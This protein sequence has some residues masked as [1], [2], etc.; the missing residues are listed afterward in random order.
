[1]YYRK[2]VGA[3]LVYDITRRESFG[4]LAKWLDQLRGKGHPEMSIILVGNKSDLGD[5]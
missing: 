4:N 3:L 2:A 1:M 5:E